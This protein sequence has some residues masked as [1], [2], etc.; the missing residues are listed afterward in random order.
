MLDQEDHQERDD[1]GRRVNCQ[2]PSVAEM[3]ER[4]DRYPNQDD[5]TRDDDCNWPAGK[6]CKRLREPGER[7]GSGGL[8]SGAVGVVHVLNLFV[9]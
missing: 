1:R 7:S 6:S 4:V 3:V 2:Q 9:R 5:Q 8:Y